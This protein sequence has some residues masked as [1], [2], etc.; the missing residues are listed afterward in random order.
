MLYSGQEVGEPA[1]ADAGFAGL[2]PRTTI[3]DYWSMPELVK[4]VNHQEYNGALLTEQQKNLRA[5]YARL[6]T[7][8]NEP[9]FRFGAF[10]PLNAANNQS[11]N[12]GAVPGDPA[13]GHWMYAFLRYDPRSRQRWLVVANL[14]RCVSFSNVQIRIPGGAIQ[15]LQ[16]PSNNSLTFTDRIPTTPTPI[17]T[18]TP[19]DLPSKGLLIPNI[20]S[21]GAMYFDITQSS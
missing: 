14:H 1:G 4:W 18:A 5:C 15:W 16:L 13:S 10:Y 7:L 12:F 3:F 21:L 19:T 6:L 17:L 20:P 8:A 9:A 2:N 11:C